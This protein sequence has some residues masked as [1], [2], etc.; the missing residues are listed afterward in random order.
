MELWNGHF[1]GNYAGDN[2]WC[3]YGGFEVIISATGMLVDIYVAIMQ[4]TVSVVFM[5]L[6]V[7]AAIMQMTVSTAN[8][9]VTIFIVIMQMGASVA[10]MHVVFSAVDYADDRFYCNYAGDTFLIAM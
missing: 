3:I 10:I 8:I 1:Y 6:D 2:N 5:H 7:S 4:V 9:W